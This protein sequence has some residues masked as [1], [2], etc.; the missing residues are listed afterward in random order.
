MK[1][2]FKKKEPAEEPIAEEVVESPEAETIGEE[3]EVPEEQIAEE[4]EVPEGLD[5]EEILEG[6]EEPSPQDM[7]IVNLQQRVSSIE[8]FLFRTVSK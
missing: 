4:V 5:E 8:A 2:I 7:V 6:Q 3:V 1:K